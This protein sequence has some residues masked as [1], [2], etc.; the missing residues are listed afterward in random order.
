MR[1]IWG[2]LG[3]RGVEGIDGQIFWNQPWVAIFGPRA[4]RFVAPAWQSDGVIKAGHRTAEALRQ[5][6]SQGA[7]TSQR[8]PMG[9][10]SLE[11]KDY[12]IEPSN[13]FNTVIEGVAYTEICLTFSIICSWTFQPP[14]FC[15]NCSATT[16][17]EW[18]GVCLACYHIYFYFSQVPP[19]V[20]PAQILMALVILLHQSENIPVFTEACKGWFVYGCGVILG[21]NQSDCR[22]E[23]SDNTNLITWP[24]ENHQYI[25]FYLVATIGSGYWSRSSSFSIQKKLLRAQCINDMSSVK[26]F[27]RPT[28]SWRCSVEQGGALGACGVLAIPL[29]KWTCACLTQN[30]RVAIKTKWICLQSR[31]FCC[32]L[33]K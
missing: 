22:F 23:W 8:K 14:P 3:S 10:S 24:Q 28:R 1:M 13:Y 27:A 17:Q 4:Q 16:W 12:Q 26:L 32:L 11:H 18:Y 20:L 6:V 9:G 30:G 21:S 2:D 19:A 25:L 33:C 5:W 7:K 29:H 31:D 15:Q